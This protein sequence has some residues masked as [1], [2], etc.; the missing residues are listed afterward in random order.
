M[1]AG[2]HI[3]VTSVSLNAHLRITSPFRES[4]APPRRHQ[5][6]FWTRN[7]VRA[8]FPTSP[9]NFGPSPCVAATNVQLYNFIRVRYIRAP[10]KREQQ[11]VDDTH[12]AII[13]RRSLFQSAFVCGSSFLLLHS[14]SETSPHGATVHARFWK[15]VNVSRAFAVGF[16]IIIVF[17]LISRDMHTETVTCLRAG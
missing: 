5:K 4:N 10:R 9:E 8:I 1:P 7:F 12:K 15:T 3:Y 6:P 14:L 13:F 17:V 11:R 2:A 16:M